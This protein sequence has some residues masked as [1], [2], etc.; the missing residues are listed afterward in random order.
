MHV[1]VLVCFPVLAL[2][3][4]KVWSYN[5]PLSRLPSTLPVMSEFTEIRTQGKQ[6]AVAT[7]LHRLSGPP[8]GT[9][10]R[11]R[12]WV[13]GSI[14]ARKLIRVA[15]QVDE[16]KRDTSTLCMM[17]SG[18]GGDEGWRAEYRRGLKN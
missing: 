3:G 11:L 1:L 9:R 12:V 5:S 10:L 17:G 14:P 16:L 8:G 2:H 18:T 13:G 4:H 7:A 6:T 15:S